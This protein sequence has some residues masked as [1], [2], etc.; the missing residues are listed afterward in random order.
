MKDFYVKQKAFSTRSRYIIYDSEDKQVYY[1]K[2]RFFSPSRKFDLYD[3]LN[4]EHL[5]QIK[6]KL[7]AWR[8]T[9]ILYN[10]KEETVATARRK[11]SF[12]KKLITIESNFGDFVIEGSFWAHDFVI[13]NNNQ[14]VASIRKKRI[15]WGD[16]YHITLQSD[17]NEAFFLALLIMIDS[18]FHQKKR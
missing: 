2:A 14:E 18:K 10:D 16:A 13:L 8:P 11:R 1:C 4:D 3:S 17:A 15:S 12:F 5:Y 6:R 9:H 7:F